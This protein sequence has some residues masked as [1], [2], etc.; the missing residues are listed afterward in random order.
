MTIKLLNLIKKET[1][2]FEV[3]KWY[4]QLNKGNDTEGIGKNTFHPIWIPDPFTVKTINLM[5]EK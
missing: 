4:D 5:K 1:C 2:T 3:Q